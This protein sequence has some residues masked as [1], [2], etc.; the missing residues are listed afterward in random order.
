[1]APSSDTARTVNTPGSVRCAISSPVVG[2]SV[3]STVERPSLLV[4]YSTD[5]SRLGT[6]P[7]CWKR[8]WPRAGASA[9]MPLALPR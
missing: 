2:S 6:A 9:V 8:T 7:V 3:C 1:M 4:A 5:Q